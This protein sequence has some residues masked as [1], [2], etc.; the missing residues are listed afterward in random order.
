MSGVIIL[1]NGH[2]HVSASNSS[3]GSIAMRGGFLSRRRVVVHLGCYGGVDIA[4]GSLELA[5]LFLEAVRDWHSLGYTAP[6]FHCGQVLSALRAGQDP[7]SIFA[8]YHEP[9]KRLF[10]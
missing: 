10:A 4:C 2:D 6:D 1:Q 8:G 9:K 3:D 5:K 7:L